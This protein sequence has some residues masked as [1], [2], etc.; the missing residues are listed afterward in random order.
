MRLKGSCRLSE[1]NPYFVDNGL[2]DGSIAHLSFAD[3]KYALEVDVRLKWKE[4]NY[5]EFEGLE[6]T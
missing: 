3:D 1:S 6:E 4:W 2:V 5:L